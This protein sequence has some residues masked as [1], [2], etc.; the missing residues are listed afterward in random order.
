MPE[1]SSTLLKYVKS[2][3]Q[4]CKVND[5]WHTMENYQAHKA[6]KHEPEYWGRQSLETGKEKIDKLELIKFYF[7]LDSKTQRWLERS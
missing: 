3:C 5:V 2:Y 1:P 6:G 4:H 7:N